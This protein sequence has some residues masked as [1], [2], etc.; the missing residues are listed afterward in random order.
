MV[1]FIAIVLNMVKH[2]ILFL[3][4]VIIC[5]ALGVVLALGVN[6]F[7]QGSLFAWSVGSGIVLFSVSC[8]AFA[9]RISKR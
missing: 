1:L 2:P 5:S 4:M 6:P 7:L 3:L 8:W 9:M